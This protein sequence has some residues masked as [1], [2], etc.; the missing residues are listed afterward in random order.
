[1]LPRL[2]R[3]QA[4]KYKMTVKLPTATQLRRRFAKLKAY[5]DACLLADEL[6]SCGCNINCDGTLAERYLSGW[7][8]AVAMRDLENH[9]EAQTDSGFVHYCLSEV[10]A[11]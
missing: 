7:N 2:Q 9:K 6:L 8:N 11:M 4:M 10:R 3:R 1:M 5:T